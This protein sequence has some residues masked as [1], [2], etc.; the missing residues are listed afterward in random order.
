M[1][2]E[3]VLNAISTE[4]LTPSKQGLA[5]FYRGNGVNGVA[6]EKFPETVQS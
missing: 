5:E 4:G 6:A 3:R 1:T 2:E